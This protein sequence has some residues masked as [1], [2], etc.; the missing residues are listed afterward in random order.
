M[1]AEQAAKLLYNREMKA[2]VDP[3]KFLEEKIKEYQDIFANPY[4]QA[5]TMN[6]DDIIEPAE[7]RFKIIQAF[8]ALKG[9]HESK[10]PRKHGN[11]PL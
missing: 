1:G 4:R 5:V 8:Q 7:T 3:E 9:K 11:I 10:H 6:I 2:S